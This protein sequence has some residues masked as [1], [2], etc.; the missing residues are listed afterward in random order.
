MVELT[1]EQIGILNLSSEK[2]NDL[3]TANPLQR[4]STTNK[5]IRTLE[6]KINVLNASIEVM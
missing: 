3:A 5:I 2:I 6:D 4:K 1:E